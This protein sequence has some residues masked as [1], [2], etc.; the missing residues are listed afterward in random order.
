MHLRKKAMYL[1]AI[2]L[3]FAF[4]AAAHKVD[5]APVPLPGETYQTTNGETVIHT[6]IGNGVYAC[7]VDTTE[8]RTIIAE[9]IYDTQKRHMG[10]DRLSWRQRKAAGLPKRLY[11]RYVDVLPINIGAQSFILKNAIVSSHEEGSGLCLGV[12]TRS[13]YGGTPRSNCGFGL[14][15]RVTFKQIQ[16]HWCILGQDAASYLPRLLPQG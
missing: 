4:T 16:T 1:A 10:L 11:E 8:P 2:S 9:N 6:Q 14:S 15:A 5:H 12:N 3:S 7:L 13:D